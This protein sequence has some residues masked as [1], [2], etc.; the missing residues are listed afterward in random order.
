MVHVVRGSRAISRISFLVSHAIALCG[1]TFILYNSLTSYVAR[2]YRQ[3]L[4]TMLC[5]RTTIYDFSYTQ[6]RRYAGPRSGRCASTLP[7]PPAV[8]RYERR[9]TMTEL[10]E[11]KSTAAGI[12]GLP[13]RGTICPKGRSSASAIRSRGQAETGKEREA[14]RARDRKAIQ[15]RGE[16]AWLNFPHESR[17]VDLKGTSPLR[18][19]V[20]GYLSVRRRAR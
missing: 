19:C 4:H 12:A 10:Q 1:L 3:Q 8:T 17:S 9:D 5:V 7:R 6:A 2:G 15:L 18:S 11:W 13:S 20:R 16:Y 14:A